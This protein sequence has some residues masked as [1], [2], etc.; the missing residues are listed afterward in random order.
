MDPIKSFME[1]GIADF[2]EILNGELCTEIYSQL[3]NNRKW[4]QDLFRSREEVSKDQQ[5]QLLLSLALLE[6]L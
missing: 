6:Y 3:L 5:L 1:T 4:G 2:G